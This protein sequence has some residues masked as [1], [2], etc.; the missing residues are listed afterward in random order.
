MSEKSNMQSKGETAVAIEGR[1]E[2]GG[3]SEC[4]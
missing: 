2:S 1:R 3:G 4:R